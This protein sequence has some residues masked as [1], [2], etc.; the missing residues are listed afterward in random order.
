MHYK[1]F[2]NKVIDRNMVPP[3]ERKSITVHTYE[4]L[5]DAIIAARFRPGEKLR[6]DS[7]KE[8]FNASLGAVR[9]ALAALAA[10]G[11]VTSEPQR[12]F[13]I[14]LISRSDLVDLTEVRVH[15][16]AACLQDAIEHG[17]IAWE[18]RILS[19]TH[20]LSKRTYAVSDPMSPAANDWRQ[21]HERFHY[22]IISACRNRWWLK[23]HKQLYAQSERYRSLSVPASDYHRDI[24][25]EHNDI[26]KAVLDRDIAAAQ[27]LLEKHMRTTTDILLKSEK[28]FATDS[29]AESQIG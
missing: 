16:D 2:P 18:G 25:T 19:V 20:Q 4:R 10:E 27:K 12:G 17:D 23:L 21:L 5:R 1:E 13:T 7:I 14:S 6:I 22:E 9:E 26:A 3:P 28:L 11:L 15:V 8:E 24:N 29:G